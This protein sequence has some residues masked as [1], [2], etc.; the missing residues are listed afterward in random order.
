[1]YFVVEAGGGVGAAFQ[2]PF[3]GRVILSGGFVM[4]FEFLNAHYGAWL[5]FALLPLTMG[6]S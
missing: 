4:N 6:S 5:N 1:M 3:E 2:I